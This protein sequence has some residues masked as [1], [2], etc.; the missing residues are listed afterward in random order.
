MSE[1]LLVFQRG[2]D[3]TGDGRYVTDL[4]SLRYDLHQYMVLVSL[5]KIY[6]LYIILN[7]CVHVH[8]FI[9]HFYLKNTLLKHRW[10]PQT[11]PD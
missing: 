10:T 7:N 6:R 11:K 9:T 3:F 4:K 2:L 5:L 8:L 1:A